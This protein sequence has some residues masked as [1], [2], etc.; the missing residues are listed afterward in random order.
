M[1]KDNKVNL[2]VCLFYLLSVKTLTYFPFSIKPFNFSQRIHSHTPPNLIKGKIAMQNIQSASLGVIFFYFA[3]TVIL[4]FFFKGTYHRL[5]DAA[6][7]LVSAARRRLAL[8]Y[9]NEVLKV[10]STEPHSY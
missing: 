10:D 3:S 5:H 4:M 7:N 8:G 6:V 2:L 1:Q 9:S